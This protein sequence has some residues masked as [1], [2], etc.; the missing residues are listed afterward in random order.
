MRRRRRRRWGRWSRCGRWCSS[1]S[2]ASSTYRAD[3]WLSGCR[4]WLNSAGCL[5][6][7]CCLN[8]RWRCKW[9]RCRGW[10]WSR[11][12]MCKRSRCRS[13]NWSRCW[14][15][16]WSRCCCWRRSLLSR[17]RGTSLS[18]CRQFHSLLNA[19]L[20]VWSSK[21]RL[22]RSRGLCWSRCRRSCERNLCRRR[23]LRLRCWCRWLRLERSRGA[24]FTQNIAEAIHYIVSAGHSSAGGGWCRRRCQWLGWRYLRHRRSWCGSWWRPRGRSCCSTLGFHLSL[25]CHAFLNR[26]FIHFAGRLR[27]LWLGRL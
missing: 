5:W 2:A 14:R 3:D 12:W 21:R 6:G 18:L 1:W 20:I 17:H 11:C 19:H 26:H 10:N 23:R 15:L 27:R 24:V 13:W 25:H 8:L 16:N 22:W 4:C 7:W 9:S